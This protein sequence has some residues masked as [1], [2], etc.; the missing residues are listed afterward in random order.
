MQSSSDAEA[1]ASQ[2][3]DS[4][5]FVFVPAFNESGSMPL[6]MLR[7][8]GG[9][10]SNKLLLQRQADLLQVC[11]CL[12]NTL[13]AVSITFCI[14]LKY[15]IISAVSSKFNNETVIL[16][17]SRT[18]TDERDDCAGGWDGSCCRLGDPRQGRDQV[19]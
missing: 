18:S 16:G 1:L 11:L 6:S 13:S 14:F 12:Q 5:S 2:V 19:Q 17:A 8:D 3:P 9:M 7:V 10:T 4:G 15:A